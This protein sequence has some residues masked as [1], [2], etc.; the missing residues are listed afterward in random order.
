[1]LFFSLFFSFFFFFFWHTSYWIQD[2]D[3]LDKCLTTCCTF[4]FFIIAILTEVRWYLIIILIYISMKSR[5]IEHL[6]YISEPLVFFLLRNA[7]LPWITYV[8]LSALTTFYSF[9]IFPINISKYSSIILHRTRN[10]LKLIWKHKRLSKQE[11]K[12]SWTK[13]QG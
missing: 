7:Y 11:P 4:I 6:S 2:L 3:L 12:Q 8:L 1:L 10:S 5:D 13:E 9:K